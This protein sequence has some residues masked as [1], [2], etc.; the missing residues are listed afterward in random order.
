MPSMSHIRRVQSRIAWL[1]AISRSE[2]CA[3][4]RSSRACSACRA[5]VRRDR[6]QPG[7]ITS[8]CAIAVVRFVTT[9]PLALRRE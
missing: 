5:R 3:C 6:R 8:A 2:R 9:G 4:A 1:E 7:E